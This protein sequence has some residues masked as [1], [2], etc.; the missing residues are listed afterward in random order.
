MKIIVAYLESNRGI[1]F[2]GKIPWKFISEDMALFQAFTYNCPVVMG[3]KTWESLPKKPLPNRENIVLSSK[4]IEGVKTIKNLLEAP[5]ESI[6]IGGQQVY[7]LALNSG[8]VNV[9]FATVIKEY[10]YECDRFFPELNKYD[11]GKYSVLNFDEF[12]IEIYLKK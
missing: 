6:I 7:E 9:V 12:N 4:D 8:L 3:R 10:D 5:K 2:K 11:W 1:G